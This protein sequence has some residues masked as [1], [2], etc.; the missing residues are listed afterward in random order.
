VTLVAWAATLVGVVGGTAGLAALLLVPTQRR[1]ARADAAS[2]IVDSA[3]DLLKPLELRAASLERDLI[4]VERIV[5]LIKREL[6]MPSPS[7]Q[8]LREIVGIDLD[9]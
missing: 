8:R 6:E 3:M 4:K 5:R 2:V 1:K 9:A 7:V